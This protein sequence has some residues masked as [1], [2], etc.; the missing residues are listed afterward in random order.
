MRKVLTFVS[1]LVV[2]F[3]ALVL[4]VLAM[5][6]RPAW[7]IRA[8]SSLGFT[9]L[10]MPMAPVV[11]FFSFDYAKYGCQRMTWMSSEK[12]GWLPRWL[13]YFQTPDNSLDGDTGFQTEH[14]QWRYKI[15]NVFWQVYVGRVLWLWRNHGYGLDYSDWMCAKMPEGITV[16]ALGNTKVRN[17]PNGSSGMC[18]WVSSNG[19][20]QICV[21]IVLPGSPDICSY[22]NLGWKIR[23]FY[24]HPEELGKGSAMLVFSP[25]F[26]SPFL[27]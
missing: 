2:G 17:R 21:V 10:S 9:L 22:I 15:S 18:D 13:W 4:S 3:I 8:L 20:W 26:F 5:I 27:A 1:G 25:R 24:E 12:D 19:Y 7:G 11:A 23:E 6:C 14:A 16:E